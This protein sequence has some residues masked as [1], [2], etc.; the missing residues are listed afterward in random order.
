MAKFNFRFNN[1]EKRAKPTNIS[2]NIHKKSLKNVLD[3]AQ[4]DSEKRLRTLKLSEYTVISQ[5]TNSLREPKYGALV[6]KIEDFLESKNKRYI[7]G[8][9]IK[10]TVVACLFTIDRDDYTANTISL[11][12]HGK[13]E[14]DKFSNIKF[15]LKK[16]LG[17]IVDAGLAVAASIS[18]DI[19]VAIF[20]GIAAILSIKDASVIELDDIYGKILKVIY[21]E[22][23][24]DGISRLELFNQMGNAGVA[25]NDI[26]E[27]IY[28]LKQYRCI[29]ETD[30]KLLL[31]E[32]MNIF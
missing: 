19:P 30:D 13:L 1:V 25:K 15:N 28:A 11:N 3:D 32:E 21:Y 2:E 31:C 6:Q 27:A 17:A 16:F 20:T 5:T 10:N 23:D 29:E 7:C 4:R 8:I 12:E 18:G 24:S 9:D 22:S 14:S 26:E